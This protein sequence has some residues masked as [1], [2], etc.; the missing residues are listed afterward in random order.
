MMILKSIWRSLRHSWQSLWQKRLF[1]G[2][3]A[4]ITAVLVFGIHRF[5]LSQQPVQVSV[6][7][8]ALERA[9][10]EPLVERFEEENPDIRLEIVEGPNATNLVE[11]L[12]TS[13][14][15]LGDSIYDLVYMDIVWT[16]KFAA[17]GWLDPL[18]DRVSEEELSEFLEGDVEG[19]RFEGQLYR[20][21]FRSD[22]G[23]LYYR[24]DLLEE[25]GFEAPDTTEE[26]IEISRALQDQGAVE[27]GYVWQGRQY[28]G[29]AAVFVEILEGHGGFWVDPD[30]EEVG[31]DEPE[32]IAAMEF[33]VQTIDDGISPRG[34]TTY[35]EEE[36]RRFFQN[37]RTVFMRNWP[38]VWTLANEDNSPVQG[39]IA[40]KPMV[41]EAGF[42]PGACQ[43]GWGLALVKD[44]PHKEEAWRV[45]EFIT[46]ESAQKEFVLNTGYVPSRR[47][48]FNDPEIVEKYSHYPDLLEVQEQ[49]VLRP[50][51][52]Q[53]A[54]ASD[55][56]QRNISS[57]L[58]GRVS[59]QRA[60]ER[61]AAETRRLLGQS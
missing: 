25:N 61:A 13:A 35:Q 56:L 23:M 21:P 39:K 41:H 15:L 60:M 20:M 47:S 10:W 29:L 11:D 43:G 14:F 30:T 49:S 44:S 46:S 48:L 50:P 57:A 17:A 4:L 37:G 12:Y 8:Q 27:W 1:Y 53:Y 40:I 26:L 16:P 31:L 58:T 19:G 52:A 51:I 38:Y 9:Q 54:Q 6:L 22:A 59:P 18:D 33:L 28:E 55:I 42:N 24:S 36:A 32:A 5:V 34:V 7:M 45:I 3:I 2:A